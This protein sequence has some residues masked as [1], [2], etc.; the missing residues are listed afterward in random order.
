MAGGNADQLNQQELARL[1][2]G[3]F[4]NPP[5]SALP[6]ANPPGS[7]PSGAG[8]AARQQRGTQ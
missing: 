1:Q 2:G 8:R 7:E 3:N 6:Y 5:A 4:G